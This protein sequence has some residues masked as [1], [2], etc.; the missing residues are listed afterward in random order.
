MWWYVFGS[1]GL[2]SWTLQAEDDPISLD[3]AIPRKAIEENPNCVLVMFPVATLT[4]DLCRFCK[5]S[6]VLDALDIHPFGHFLSY[7]PGACQLQ[8]QVG[9]LVVGEDP[10]TPTWSEAR[11]AQKLPLV[12]AVKL[13]LRGCVSTWRYKQPG[14]R[15]TRL[16]L[17]KRGGRSNP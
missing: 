10:D 1:H 8:W 11:S 9:I 13:F 15:S 16:R 12:P 5:S 6:R 17:I 4:T 2:H 14:S 3:A 7:F